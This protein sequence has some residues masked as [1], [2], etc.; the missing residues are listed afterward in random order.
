M[1]RHVFLWK[2]AKGANAQEIIRI[3]D[4][5]PGKVPGIRTWSRG[6]HQGPPG[7][8]GGLWDGALI[9]DFDSW[10]ALARYSNHPFH[11]EV[12]SRLIPMFADR[13]VCDFELPVG[14]QK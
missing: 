12:V 4:E 14:E 3:L 13:A 6:R 1:I 10:E 2:V 8:S 7:D 11:S 5:L 9:S